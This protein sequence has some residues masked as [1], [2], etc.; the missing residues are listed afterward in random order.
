[1]HTSSAQRV[2]AVERKIRTQNVRHVAAT[3]NMPVPFA[4]MVHTIGT[5]CCATSSS[6]HRQLR[7]HNL[8]ARTIREGSLPILVAEVDLI[9]DSIARL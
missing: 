9:R 7:A 3:L 5:G 4:N 1:M 8:G 6:A 2:G